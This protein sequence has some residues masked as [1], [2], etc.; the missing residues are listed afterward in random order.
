MIDPPGVGKGLSSRG[1]TATANVYGSHQAA[2]EKKNKKEKLHLAFQ[3]K[4]G[5]Q[6]SGGPHT[7]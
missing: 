7:S 2:P 1:L 5:S 6:E 4:P 3:M